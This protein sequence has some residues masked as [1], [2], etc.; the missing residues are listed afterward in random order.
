MKIIK[1]L[2]E[3]ID[4]EIKDARKYADQALKLKE[5]YPTCADLFYRLS[6]EELEHMSMLHNE[7]A[8]IIE[9]HR[10][11]HGE[12]PAAMMAVYDYL[13]KKQIEAV[14]EIKTMRA[15]YEE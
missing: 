9:K 2:T 8:R 13:H 7:A 12:P 5:E 11:E 3:Y 4:D 1:M 15:M 6:G 10:K 14:T